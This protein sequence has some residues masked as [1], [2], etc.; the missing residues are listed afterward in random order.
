[1]KILLISYYF[2]PY[3]AVG[4]VRPGKLARFL[5]R[6]GH[7]V[8]VLTAA[9][10]PV[11]MGL[12]LEIAATLVHEVQGW[13]VNA[14]LH[15]LLGGRAK[16]A[17]QGFQGVGKGQPWV[18]RLG[19]MYKTLLHWPDAEMG[20]V[21]GAHAEGRRL[22]SNDDFDLIYVTAPPYSA[23]RVGARLSREHDLPWVA[24][25][26]D[27]WVDNHA[28]AHPMW[29]RKLERR[30]EASLLAGAAA[31]VTVSPPLAAKLRRYD[32]PVWEICN[33]FDPDDMA[34]V[35]SALPV[36]VNELR[37]VY[38][39][40]IYTGYYDTNMFCAGIAKFV[41]NGGRLRVHVVGRNVA[42]I[43]QTAENH[44]VQDLFDVQA[45]VPRPE[46]LALQQSADILLLFLWNTGEGG[47]Y[48][49]KLFEYA[50]TSRPILAVGPYGCDVAQWIRDVGI[51]FVASEP[52]SLAEQLKHWQEEKRSK[53]S[54]SVVPK[55]GHDFTRG[56][57]FAQLE[58]HLM[59]LVAKHTKGR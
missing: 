56:T 37:I 6:L 24:E 59:E 48:T 13:S 20:W 34:D 25:F 44:G 1:M 36:D 26:R 43:V 31:L 8:H 23:L 42:A 10:P 2:P 40:N 41:L 45:T 3:N 57:Q 22:L 18:Q 54:L 11:A 35:T 15:F 19:D 55:V 49:T 53:G 58:S 21:G 33:G 30:W 38:T 14:P 39:G 5:Q 27:L 46:A 4:A 47:I 50:A 52:A 12:P 7:E 51:G 9:D 17:I 16:V 29:R 28:Y 32:K